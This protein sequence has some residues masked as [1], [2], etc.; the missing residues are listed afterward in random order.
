MMTKED[1][2]T[3]EPYFKPN[4]FDSP[5]EVGSGFKMQKRFM[6]HLLIARKIANI[7]FK[8]SSGYRTREHNKKVGGKPNSSHLRGLACDIVCYSSQTRYKIIIAL[9][10]AGFTRIGIGKNFIHCDLDENKVQE[11]IWTYYK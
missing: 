11:V 5:D 3:Y 9:L 1:W 2:K 6:N 4:E 8:I 7:P 10:K